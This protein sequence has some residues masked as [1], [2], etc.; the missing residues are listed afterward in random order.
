M[1][2]KFLKVSLDE[3]KRKVKMLTELDERIEKLENENSRKIDGV[4][5][6]RQ[7]LFEEMVTDRILKEDDR[8]YHQIEDAEYKELINWCDETYA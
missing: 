5:E 6:E 3:A 2:K 4:K 1:E 8:F 7:K